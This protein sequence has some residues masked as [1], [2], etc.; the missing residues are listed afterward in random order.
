VAGSRSL[1]ARGSIANSRN[2]KEFRVIRLIFERCGSPIETRREAERPGGHDIKTFSKLLD[3]C[4]GNSRELGTSHDTGQPRLQRVELNLMTITVLL[5]VDEAQTTNVSASGFRRSRLPL[6]CPSSDD[7]E[8][9]AMFSC[10]RPILPSVWDDWARCEGTAWLRDEVVAPSIGL[11]NKAAPQTKWPKVYRW[12][13]V[14]A[15]TFR[16]Y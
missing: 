16:L 4:T 2:N 8:K 1:C 7:L 14:G 10:Q 5:L 12:N 13:F 9:K 6:P 15:M 3:A 11:K